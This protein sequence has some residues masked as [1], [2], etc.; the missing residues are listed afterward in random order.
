MTYKLVEAKSNATT[1]YFLLIDDQIVSR[2][3]ELTSNDY[4]DLCDWDNQDQAGIDLTD[5]Q[6]DIDNGTYELTVLCEQ[7]GGRQHVEQPTWA[8]ALGQGFYYFYDGESGQLTVQHERYDTDPQFRSHMAPTKFYEAVDKLSVRVD[9]TTVVHSGSHVSA[10]VRP[11]MG[12]EARH[13]LSILPRQQIRHLLTKFFDA[14]SAD[15]DPDG[16][17]LIV[18]NDES[19]QWL[20]KDDVLRFNEHLGQLILNHI[21]E[22][23]GLWEGEMKH[24]NDMK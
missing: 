13:G 8:Q 3:A 18:N 4:G 11:V 14:Q 21:N 17:I 5:Y 10:K 16:H 2:W 12:K 9:E 15:I 19:C 6:T 23:T 20:E 7:N 22:R 24:L 1:E